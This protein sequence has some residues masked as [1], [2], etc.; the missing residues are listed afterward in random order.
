MRANFYPNAKDALTGWP[1]PQAAPALPTRGLRIGACMMDGRAGLPYARDG[2]ALD[3]ASRDS[4]SH[5]GALNRGALNILAPTRY[6][7]RFNAPRHSRHHIVNRGFVPLNRLSHRVEGLTV[8]NPLPPRRFDLVHAYNRIPLGV[9]PFVIGFESHLPRAFGSQDSALF[10]AMSAMLA[11]PRCRRIVAISRYARG[12]F[13]R[14]HADGGRL[15]ALSPKLEVRYPSI[16]LPPAPHE[17]ALDGGGIRLL[18]VGG[19][20]AR[21][22]GCVALRIAEIADRRGLPLSL[23][24]VSSFDV[25]AA[26]WVDPTRPGFF[27]TE[28]RLVATLPNVTDHGALANA[29]VRALMDD[30]HFL[31]LPSFSDSFG[32]GAMEAMAHGVPVI[33]THQGAFPEFVEDGRNGFLLPLETDDWGEWTHVYRAD[34]D[35]PAYEALFRAEI[36]R[37]AA[38]ALSRIEA[39]AGTPRYAA[40]RRAARATAARLFDAT[41]ADAYWD[42]LYAE[43]A[44]PDS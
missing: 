12:Q 21:K 13:L 43:A 33:A 31:M 40:M 14:Q 35:Q 7:W 38:A 30:A 34:R 15:D 16:D 41:A 18:F 28:R 44:R 27:D 3:R 20:F 25:G 1:Y 24:I 5:Q 6:P 2:G 17:A 42:A 39:V 10:R 23:S 36:D 9:T 22:G 11:A 4:A 8:I 29:E 37:L 32:F 19:H 26:S